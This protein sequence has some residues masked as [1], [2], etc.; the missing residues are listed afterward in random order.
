M[1]VD[2]IYFKS[3]GKFYAHGSYDTSLTDLG[4][5][6]LEVDRMHEE[7]NLPGLARGSRGWIISVRVP[8]HPHDHPKLLMGDR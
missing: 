3:T 6:W 4:D 1:Q 7:G 8:A 2:L 5:I